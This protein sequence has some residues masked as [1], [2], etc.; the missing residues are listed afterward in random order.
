MSTRRGR[1]LGTVEWIRGKPYVRVRLPD[2]TRPRYPIP[3]DVRPEDIDRVATAIA[4]RKTER[5]HTELARSQLARITVRDFGEL[6]TSGELHR[7]Y[8]EIKGLKPKRSAKQD[9]YRLSAYVYPLVGNV[10]VADVTEEMIE[11][12]L[13][14][15]PRTAEERRGKPWSQ[16]SKRQL[17]QLVSRLF[18]LAIRPARLRPDSPVSADLKPGRGRTKLFTYLY[19]SE[20]LALLGCREVPLGRRIH[21]ALAAYT[22][23]R[24][25]SLLELRWA[26]VEFEHRTLTCLVNKIDVPQLFEIGDDLVWLLERWRERCGTPPPDSPVVRDRNCKAEREAEIIREDLKRAGVTRRLLFDGG[27]HNVQPIRFHDLRATFVTWALRAGR[28]RGW[29]TDRTGHL[30]EAMMNRYARQA[31]TLADLDYEPFPDLRLAIPELAEATAELIVLGDRRR[32]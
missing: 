31:R 29:I 22:G 8:G 32:G 27:P 26:D 10:A 4:Q 6:W 3:D 21:Y 15:A 20:L 25:R 7:R 2:G 24:K 16:G 9:G 14:R 23:L 11:D 18:D 1:H 30:T 12:L 17:F 28:G 19:P 5:V 13:A